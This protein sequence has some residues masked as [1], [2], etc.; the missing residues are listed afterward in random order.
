MCLVVPII[1]SV[2]VAVHSRWTATSDRGARAYH[3]KI[4]IL[5]LTE[6]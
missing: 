1:K 2:K 6:R 4:L 3:S 5:S